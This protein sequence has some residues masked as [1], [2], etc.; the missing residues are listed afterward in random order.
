MAANQKPIA[1]TATSDRQQAFFPFSGVRFGSV[2]RRTIKFGTTH[3]SRATSKSPISGYAIT[4][5]VGHGSSN[6]ISDES[7]ASSFSPAQQT[8]ATSAPIS[9][10]KPTSI[11]LADDSPIGSNRRSSSHHPGDFRKGTQYAE[12][13]AIRSNGCAPKP[14]QITLV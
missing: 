3:Q 6:E 14:T 13:Y 12:S 4:K 2:D 11:Y 8:P 7:T 1:S 10:G 9:D 5:S